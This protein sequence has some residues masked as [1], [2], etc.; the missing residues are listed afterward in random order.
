[1]KLVLMILSICCTV[2]WIL[3]TIRVIRE[4]NKYFSSDEYKK[5]SAIREK[6]RQDSKDIEA[7]HKS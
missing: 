3:L 2:I 7:K 4:N 1:M 5:Q 6:L